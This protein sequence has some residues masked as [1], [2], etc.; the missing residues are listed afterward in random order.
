MM[1][2]SI[3][4]SEY[5]RGPLYQYWKER[6][7][8]EKA[9]REQ[10]IQEAKLRSKGFQPLS[11]ASGPSSNDSYVRRATS[12]PPGY[13]TA[14][15]TGGGGGDQVNPEGRV[16]EPSSSNVAAAA[17]TLR[18]SHLADSDL[19]LPS[20]TDATGSLVR[21]PSPSPSSSA[22]PPPLVPPAPSSTNPFRASNNDDP[23]T[24]SLT[25]TGQGQYQGQYQCQGQGQGASELLLSA[26]DE[27]ARLAQL[28]ARRRQIEQDAT[29]AARTFLSSSSPASTPPA[30]TTTTTTTQVAEGLP[31]TLETEPAPTLPTPI[32]TRKSKSTTSK[33]G[34]WISDA[35]TGYSKRQERF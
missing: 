14:T 17:G 33:I 34:R 25:P 11:P 20:Y 26:T 24:P 13:L 3:F 28:E 7:A 9:T 19:L 16:P 18:R 15:A 6:S 29:M 1:P 30:T 27:K 32:P 22:P 5:S 2:Q 10:R 12:G 35:A 4:S 21:S 8:E 23:Q 31:G